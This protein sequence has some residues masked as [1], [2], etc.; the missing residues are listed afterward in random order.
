MNDE[1]YNAEEGMFQEPIL[2]LDYILII[3]LIYGH[4]ILMKRLCFCACLCLC[5]YLIILIYG[6]VIPMIR[7]CLCLCFSIVT[8]NRV[9]NVLG[10]LMGSVKTHT[11]LVN[12][13]GS[14]FGSTFG[15]QSFGSST[16]TLQSCIQSDVFV[17]SSILKLI[18]SFLLKETRL[19]V[20]Y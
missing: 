13:F 12:T 14:T 18:C 5:L 11:G 19:Q 4:V 10:Q 2:S 8:L 15:I 1:V 9:R 7:L 20:P 6:H 16:R 3:I 17:C